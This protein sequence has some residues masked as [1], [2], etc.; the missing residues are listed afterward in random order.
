MNKIMGKA[1]YGDGQKSDLKGQIGSI[2]RDPFGVNPLYYIDSEK[3]FFWASEMKDLI[4]FVRE[5]DL[6]W[7]LNEE[8][9]FEYMMFRYTAGRN[10]LIK[11]VKRVL[12]GAL[13]LFDA[14]TSGGLLISIAPDSADGL[15]KALHSKGIID[16][17]IIGDVKEESPEKIKV[18]K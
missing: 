8:V 12:P 1:V 10:T 6:D 2:S 9:L 16:A 15:L 13:I 3:G 5:Y 17:A 14:Q 11:E 4:P 7:T 18:I